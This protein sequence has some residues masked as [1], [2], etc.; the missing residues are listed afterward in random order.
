LSFAQAA[1]VAT[2]MPPDSADAGICSFECTF[3]AHCAD[4]VLKGTCPNCGGELVSRPRRAA[5]KLANNP[6]NYVHRVEEES[7][8]ET[9]ALNFVVDRLV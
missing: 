8:L 3:C 1:S 9:A 4:E 2:L 6:P 7:A 5:N